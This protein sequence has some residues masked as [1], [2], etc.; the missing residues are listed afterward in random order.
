MIFNRAKRSAWWRKL[1][2]HPV[3]AYSSFLSMKSLGVRVR[4]RVRAYSSFLSMK[5][6]GVS[7]LPLGWNARPSQGSTNISPSFPGNSS[8]LIHTLGWRK[9]LWERGLFPK[10][11]TRLP[12]QVSFPDLSTSSPSHWTFGRRVSRFPHSIN[13]KTSQLQN[14]FVFS[15]SIYLT[16]PCVIIFVFKCM[17]LHLQSVWGNHL[18]YS[19]R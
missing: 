1:L 2:T 8:L 11:T 5:S 19:S 10:N 17:S 14:Y 16:S 4:V 9:A 18:F 3:R 12:N 6:L 7:P 13:D 15:S